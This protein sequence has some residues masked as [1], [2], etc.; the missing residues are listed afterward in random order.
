MN[1]IFGLIFAT[2]LFF[3]VA[4][5]AVAS[6]VSSCQ[7][8]YG[9]GETCEEK[10]KFT[11]NKL[12]KSPAK[13]GAFVENLTINDPRY[14][15]GSNISFKITVTNSGNKDITNLNVVDQFPQF[16]T[17]VSGA[18]SEEHTSELQS[19]CNLVCR[20]LLEKKKMRR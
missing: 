11:I 14:P 9:G 13:D 18:R 10:V 2:I 20:H 5:T 17:F 12:V 4:S 8:I 16:L 3:S 19:P 1:K 7:P 6:G 15:A